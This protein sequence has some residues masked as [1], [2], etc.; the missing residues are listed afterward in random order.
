MWPS[1]LVITLRLVVP[2]SLKID[3]LEIWLS[4]LV[5]LVGSAALHRYNLAD[6]GD[7]AREL[8]PLLATNHEPN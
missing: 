1:T 6:S 5:Q 4:G 8:V 7:G 3:F 2:S